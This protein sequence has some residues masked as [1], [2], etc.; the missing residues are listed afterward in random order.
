MEFCH[1]KCT[2]PPAPKDS[3]RECG[4]KEDGIWACQYGCDLILQ[5]LCLPLCTPRCVTID[6]HEAEIAALR[7][8]IKTHM[9]NDQEQHWLDTFDKVRAEQKSKSIG[10]RE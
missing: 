6:Q 9:V 4:Y 2:Q 7:E 10:E 5:P 1:C 8:A 3:P